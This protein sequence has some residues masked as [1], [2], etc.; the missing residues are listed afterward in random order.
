MRGS[1]FKCVRAPSEERGVCVWLRACERL[2]YTEA[3]L[4][5]KHCACFV[6]VRGK[7]CVCVGGGIEVCT[8][9]YTT[10]AVVVF[11]LPCSLVTVVY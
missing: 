11:A 1:V 9:R 10:S 7:R 8:V 6:Y 4:K 3:V 2:H 5:E